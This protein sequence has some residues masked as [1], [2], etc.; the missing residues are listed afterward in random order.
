LGKRKKLDPQ[1]SLPT[2]G[3]IRGLEV[4]KGREKECRKGRR[5]L[6]KVD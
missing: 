3:M 2:K 5:G 4:T 6:A 1:I